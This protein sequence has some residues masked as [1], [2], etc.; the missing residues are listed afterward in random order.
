MRKWSHDNL[1][2]QEQAYAM[3][4]LLTNLSSSPSFRNYSCDDDMFAKEARSINADSNFSDFPPMSGL[5]S[6][7]YREELSG[8]YSL[9]QGVALWDPKPPKEFYDK[10]S[11]GDVGYLQEGIF[12]RMFNVMLPWD[13]P[14]NNKL[15]D[16]E[17]YEPLDQSAF[18]RIIKWQ[19]DRVEHY[20]RSVSKSA[21]SGAD[22][23]ADN[24]PATGPDE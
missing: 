4:G 21:E 11:I 18:V 13:H 19:F 12:I 17:F 1:D 20:S 22:T 9:R 8:P 10:V 23:N 24:M 7:V 16:L 5:S 14:S 3:K 15:G 2:Y 6:D